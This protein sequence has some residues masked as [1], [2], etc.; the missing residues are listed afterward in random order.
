MRR[1]ASLD[2]RPGARTFRAR[3]AILDPAFRPLVI[4]LA[5]S[6]IATLTLLVALNAAGPR[7]PNAQ[8]L[9]LRSTI[10]D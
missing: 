10:A 9:G 6:V 1:L 7:A 3:V 4:A 2:R 8:E 5:V